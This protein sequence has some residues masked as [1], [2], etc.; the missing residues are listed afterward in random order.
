MYRKYRHWHLLMDRQDCP[1]DE[2]SDGDCNGQNCEAYGTVDPWQ[3][4][5]SKS[6]Y[7]KM[8][9]KCPQYFLPGH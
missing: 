5:L 2:Q 1:S 6:C 8:R 3:E 9:F 7:P 4:G